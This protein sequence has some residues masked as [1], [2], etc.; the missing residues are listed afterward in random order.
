VQAV[1]LHLW[2]P[3]PLLRESSVLLALAV[4]CVVP[5]GPLR[6]FPAGNRQPVL[7]ATVDAGTA[8]S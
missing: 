6:P 7:A 2:S 4:A 5:F 8:G 1:L 3:G